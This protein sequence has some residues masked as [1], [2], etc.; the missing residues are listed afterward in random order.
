METTNV[1][2]ISIEEWNQIFENDNVER[3]QKI[4]HLLDNSI[5]KVN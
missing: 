1:R 3:V 5:K 2:L 4:F